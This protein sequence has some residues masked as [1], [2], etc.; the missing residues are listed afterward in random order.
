MLRFG[1]VLGAVLGCL[2]GGV[3]ARA[4]NVG[5][6]FWGT[7]SY[8]GDAYMP[9][10]GA[11][12]GEVTID[13]TPS[14]AVYPNSNFP[15]SGEITFVSGSSSF[16]EVGSPSDSLWSE[17]ALGGVGL[18]LGYEYPLGV[19]FEIST[20]VPNVDVFQGYLGSFFS[21]YRTSNGDSG[22]KAAFGR[23]NTLRLYGTFAAAPEPG[24]WGLLTLGVGLAGAALRRR[25]AQPA[26]A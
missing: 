9:A 17:D 4:A 26:A 14:Y 19:G 2:L 12:S 16:E 18:L 13:T 20:T 5:Y 25:R 1:V 15:A 8:A 23:N 7:Y 24:A 11:F 3:G 21:T 6:V 10:T 22:V